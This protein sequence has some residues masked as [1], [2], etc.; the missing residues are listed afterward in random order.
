MK[1]WPVPDSDNKEVPRHG[2]SGSFWEDRGDRHH[3]GIDI[4][5]PKGSH[6]YAAGE[7]KVIETG[8]FTKPETVPYWNITYYILIKDS[9]TGHYSRWAELDSAAV[10]AGDTVTS[11][12]LIGYV[13]G[14][15]NP[16]KIGSEAPPYIQRLK[17]HGRLSM[18]H[19]ELYGEHAMP[20]EIRLCLG[21]NAPK[22]T[23]PA[24]LLDPTDYFQDTVNQEK[25]SQGSVPAAK[26]R[27]FN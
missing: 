4:Y 23:K 27:I 13:G 20:D 1:R 17:H 22:G 19:F 9:D 8:I 15:L 5:A 18:L 21:G 7:G 16:D 24:N 11:G 14:V 26:I 2:E 6:I 12:Q 25:C 10:S 3:C